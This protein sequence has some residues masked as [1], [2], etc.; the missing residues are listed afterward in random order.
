MKRRKAFWPG[1]KWR[2]L[3]HHK[4]TES[5]KPDY[6]GDTYAVESWDFRQ[7][8]EIDELC[9][10]DWFHLEQMDSRDWWIGLGNGDDYWN[11]NIHIDRDGK[12]Q[13]SMEKT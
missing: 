5:G 3:A 11:I 12:A 6:T 8:T 2:L 9:I 4:A 7:L 10:D 1:Y 13:V